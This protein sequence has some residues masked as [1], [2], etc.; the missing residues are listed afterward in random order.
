MAYSNTTRVIRILKDLREISKFEQPYDN[1]SSINILKILTTA[2]RDLVDIFPEKE[3]NLFI[4][5]VNLPDQI[6]II[7]NDLVS[8]IFLNIFTNAVKFTPGPKVT[9]NITLETLVKEQEFVKITITDFGQGI[10]PKYKHS[11]F[12]RSSLLK[13]GWKPSKD[14]TGLGMSIIKS[15]VDFFGGSI[16]YQNRIK[17]DWTKGT[18]IILLFP[19]AKELSSN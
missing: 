6:M 12:D 17:D 11:L 4:Q 5:P 13:N 18:S 3:I 8:E 15:L 1:L 9:I 7:A 14:S 2:K 10:P 16:R 19:S